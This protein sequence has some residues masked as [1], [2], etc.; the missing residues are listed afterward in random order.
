[1]D[2]GQI[3]D[4]VKNIFMGLFQTEESKLPASY[5]TDNFFGSRLH[6]LPGDAVAYL[7]AIEKAFELQVPS[8]YILEGKFNSLD[9]VTDI[10]FDILQKR[11]TCNLQE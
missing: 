1:M 2:R 9:N 11:E 5:W 4:K 8:S 7:Y 10:I 3:S 6:I